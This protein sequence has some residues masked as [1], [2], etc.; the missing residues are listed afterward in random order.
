MNLHILQWNIRSVTYNYAD[1]I[2]IICKENPDVFLLNETWLEPNKQFRIKNYSSIREDRADGYGGLA[3]LVNT[4]V[5]F[6]TLNIQLN[7]NWRI[8]IMGIKVKNI[9]IYTIYCPPD[10]NLS[11]TQIEQIL[12][13]LEEPFVLMGDLNA[14]HSN[15]TQPHY[16]KLQPTNKS[17]SPKSR[18]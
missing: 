12:G 9:S 17:N 16:C 4:G 1:L 7:I 8:Q 6:Q 13:Q 14:Q 15:R 5:P 11:S 2:F 10:I 3:I 18:S